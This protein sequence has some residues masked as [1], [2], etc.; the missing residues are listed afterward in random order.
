MEWPRNHECRSVGFLH[1]T[2]ALRSMDSAVRP[3][4][5]NAGPPLS[6]PTAEHW[7]GTDELGRD[8]LSRVDRRHTGRRYRR[9]FVRGARA[10]DRWELWDR[11]RLL[12]PRGRYRDDARNGCPLRV[13]RT[14]PGHHRHRRS[15][16]ISENCSDRD[17][18]RLCATVR[19]S[20]SH[21][22]T[23][24]HGAR[25]H[26]GSTGFFPALRPVFLQPTTSSRTSAPP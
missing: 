17:L 26:R 7:F 23:D 3:N 20:R 10:R 18:F 16:A 15:R 1:R 5:L 2:R 14:D 24:R 4:E 21:S 22:N 6:P 19:Q 25:V 8:Q 9:I 13:P 12:P 11:S